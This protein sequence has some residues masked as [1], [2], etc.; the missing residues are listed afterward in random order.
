MNNSPR[1]S[2][3][4]LVTKLDAPFDV[5]KF[6]CRGIISTTEA[7]KLRDALLKMTFKKKSCDL[8]SFSQSSDFIRSPNLEK[9]KEVEQFLIFLKEIKQNIATYLGKKFNS[10][11]SASCSKYDRGDYLLCHDDRVDDRSVAFIYYLN[12]DWL[13]EWGGTL[14]VYSVDNMNCAKEIVKNI[15]PE[16]NSMIFFPVEKYTYHQV[17]ENTSAFSRVSING[18]FH[19]DELSWEMYDHP[20]KCLSPIYTPHLISP[21]RVKTAFDVF[22]DP[23]YQDNMY[24]EAVRDIFIR[25]GFIMCEGFFKPCMVDILSNEIFSNSMNWKIKGPLNKRQYKHV[26]NKELPNSILFIVNMLKTDCMFKFFQE[27]SGLEFL[28]VNIEVQRWH[29][30]HY[31]VSGG[32]DGVAGFDIFSVYFFFSQC[33]GDMSSADEDMHYVF[34]EKDTLLPKFASTPQHN[35][36]LLVNHD[37]KTDLYVKYCKIVDGHAWTVVVANYIVKNNLDSRILLENIDN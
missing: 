19:C 26:D 7:F 9:P 14:D 20:V 1:F 13:P 5:F 34:E 3:N 29:G 27:C 22:I 36:M 25:D 12:Y 35:T 4:D 2:F 6:D 15:N 8:Y 24:R 11:I 10:M 17:A 16:F 28:G 21:D 32:N 33:F 31:M 23:M 18:W 37:S 30:G